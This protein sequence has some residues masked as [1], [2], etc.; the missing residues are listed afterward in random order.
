MSWQLAAFLIGGGVILCVG[1]IAYL[2]F[3]QP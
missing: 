1:F 3:R 2:K